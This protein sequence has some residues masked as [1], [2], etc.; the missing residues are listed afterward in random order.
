MRFIAA[1]VSAAVCASAHAQRILLVPIDSRPATGQFAQMI[2]HIADV[3][4]QM[5]PYET[6]GRFTKPGDPG[7][8]LA[9]LERQDYSDVSAVV[10]SADMIAY[11]G[12]IA[13]RKNDVSIGLALQR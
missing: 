13:S 3:Q 5:P 1:V 8:I 6:L 12:L 2:A 11:G 7:L 9:W 10:V 4:V